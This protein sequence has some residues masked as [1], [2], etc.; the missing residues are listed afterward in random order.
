MVEAER[1][2]ES[3]FGW[4]RETGD[5]GTERD[6]ES[7]RAFMNDLWAESATG[8]AVVCADIMPLCVCGGEWVVVCV[9]SFN[10]LRAKRAAGRC[11]RVCKCNT[12]MC[13][14]G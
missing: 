12:F 11:S 5:K 13:V 4:G 8:V 2:R 3:V 10:N 9:C 6:R 14:R 1:Q 7:A